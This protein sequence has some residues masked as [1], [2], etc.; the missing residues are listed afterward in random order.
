MPKE[1]LV[2]VDE[3]SLV[4]FPQTSIVNSKWVNIAYLM[5]K[6]FLVL[7]KI[8]TLF[9][10]VVE[11]YNKKP[12]AYSKAFTIENVPW[13]F[14]I[15]LHEH[16]QHMGVLVRFSA[17][18]WASYQRSYF[19]HFGDKINISLFL[20]M[21]YSDTYSYRLSRI[22]IT[23]DYKNYAISPDNI[24]NQLKNNTLFIQDCKGRITKRRISAVQN[25]MIT[26]TFYVGSR[27]ENSQMLLRVYDKKKEQLCNNG[28]R[29]KEATKCKDW[30]RF[31]VSYRGDYAHQITD[32][33]ID[34][35]KSEEELTKFLADK[36][37]NKYRFV[38]GSGNYTDFTKDLL[39]LIEDGNYSALRSERPDNN[40]LSKSIAHI[41]KG[42]GL[43]PLLF[44]I[45]V[46]W[47][48]E[49]VIKF[50][51]IIYK[52]Y[53]EY[54]REEIGKNLNLIEWLKKNYSSLSKQTLESC[55]IGNNMNDYDIDNL[56]KS[57][58][59]FKE[60]KE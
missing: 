12:S 9:G 4:L 55:F 24:Y 39:S 56:I 22:D 28:F 1:L 40:S 18:A 32:Q 14:A 23:A 8:E 59:I 38:N 11:M 30:T 29:M 34:S 42:S 46:I 3:F 44:K 19:E 27:K 7:S 52:I 16:F 31:E 43:Y 54:Y 13:Y 37:C 49:T 36:I 5:I 20:K 50:F 48:E 57:E 58:P 10:E 60:I 6:E 35:I 15:A 21:T 53:L 45:E 41:I 2:G 17:Q 33:I 47:N 26:D 51:E 25:N